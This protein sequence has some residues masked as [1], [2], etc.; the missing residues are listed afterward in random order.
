MDPTT[1][2]LLA[3]GFAL[4]AAL[5]SSVG[6]AG[7]SGYLALMALAGLMPVVMRPTALVV[8]VVVATIG[9]YHFSRA[10]LTNWR[11]LLPLVG[12]SVPLAF[13]GGTIELPVH[14]Y[15]W[16][17]G[18]VLVASALVIAVRAYGHAGQASVVEP[19]IDLPLA[20]AIAIGLVI[21]LLSGL[22]G[23]GGGIFLS[24]L[25]LLAGRAGPRRTAGLAAPFIR[26]NSLAGIAGLGWSQV[27]FPNGL[28]W[29]VL[30]VLLGGLLGA[31]LGTRRLPAR[32]LLSLLAAVLFIAG[33]KL[34][35]T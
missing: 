26:L 28:P 2:L 24:P 25:L 17:V 5:Y 16:L 32:V 9:T 30:A 31:K 19:A 7:A 15:R 20:G 22:T 11:A 8:N 1:L 23:T 14:G 35:A 34:F 29:L 18:A 33:A 10:G 6:H 12:A 27:A 13:I 4:V 21:G 3:C